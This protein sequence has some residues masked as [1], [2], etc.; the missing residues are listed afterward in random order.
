MKLTLTNKT[1]LVR[2][3]EKASDLLIKILEEKV[4]SPLEAKSVLDYLLNSAVNIDLD[5][6]SESFIFLNIFSLDEYI[7]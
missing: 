7:K 2:L 3:S 1:E 6:V 4:I 5:K